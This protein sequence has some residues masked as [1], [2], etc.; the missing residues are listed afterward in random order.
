MPLGEGAT[1]PST[2]EPCPTDEENEQGKSLL[3][4]ELG[5]EAVAN[6][7]APGH[8]CSVAFFLRWDL[9]RP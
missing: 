4:L 5:T 2:V 8:R 1:F 6:P 9:E 3:V 7:R